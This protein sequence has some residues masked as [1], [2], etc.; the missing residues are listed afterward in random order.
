[1]HKVRF[2]IRFDFPAIRR[3]I[4]DILLISQFSIVTP[5][6][7]GIMLLFGRRRWISVIPGILLLIAAGLATYFFIWLISV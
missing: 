6:I 7:P 2:N 5:A 3:E 1:M 4:D